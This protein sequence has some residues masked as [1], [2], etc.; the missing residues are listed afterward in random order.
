MTTINLEVRR[1]NLEAHIDIDKEMAKQSNSWY[2]FE[3][4]VSAGKIVSFVIREYTDYAKPKA[5]QE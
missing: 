4:L 1:E 3:L 2:H 5:E